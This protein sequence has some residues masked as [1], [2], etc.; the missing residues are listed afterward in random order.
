MDTSL[1]IIP[2]TAFTVLDNNVQPEK[3]SSFNLSKDT[4]IRYFQA[5]HHVRIYNDSVQAVCD[6]LFYS[7]EDSTFRLF[8]DPLV[9]SSKSQIAG[10]TIFLF[11]KNKKASRVYVFEKGIIINEVNK[12]MYNQVAG[13]TLN[14]YFKDGQLDYMRVKGSPAESVFYPQDD[15]S[16]ITGMNRCHGDVIDIYFANKEVNKVKFVND[17]TGALYPLYQIPEDQKKLPLFNWQ[18]ARRPKNKLELFE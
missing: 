4:A 2:D 9:F 11:T 5:F 18:D 8:K 15:D 12:Q 1:A 10:D 7:S 14:G 17:V 13:R 6:S 3:D 16:A